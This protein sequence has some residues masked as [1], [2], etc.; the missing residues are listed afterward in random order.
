MGSPTVSCHHK[1]VAPI[2]RVNDSRT[3]LPRN[4]LSITL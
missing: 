4:P 2:H 1:I 3:F